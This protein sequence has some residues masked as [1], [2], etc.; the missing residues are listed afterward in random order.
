MKAHTKG[1]TLTEV[2]IV[3]AMLAIVS[4]IVVPELSQASPRVQETLLI[5]GL[6]TLRAAVREYRE[7]HGG[8]LP[9]GKLLVAQLTMP[10]NAH[11]DIAPEGVAS[12]EYRFGPY[13]E[14]VPSNPFVNERASSAVEIGREAPGG[15]NAG[16]YFNVR[17]GIIYA[18]DDAHAGK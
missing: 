4:L 17:T 16:W 8:Q 11:G 13:L 9:D 15:G 14:F 12:E 7:D 1:L 6:Q 18:D 3:V 10:T 2:G 5:E